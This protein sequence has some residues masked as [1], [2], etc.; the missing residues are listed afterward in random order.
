MHFAIQVSI[1]DSD[2]LEDWCPGQI[3][4]C[5][6]ICGGKT[7]SNTCSLFV[8]PLPPKLVSKS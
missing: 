7:S 2:V 3:E 1:A 4:A 5:G 8:Y 6:F